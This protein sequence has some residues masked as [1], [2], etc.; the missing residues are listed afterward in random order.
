MSLCASFAPSRQKTSTAS[1]LLRVGCGLLVALMTLLISP[2][3]AEERLRVGMPEPG[4]I[5]FLWQDEDGR[6][7]GIYADTL[8]RVAEEMGVGLEFVPLS[9][10]RLR[11][12]FIAGEIDIEAGVSRSLEVP[13]ALE[14]VSL[15]SL[16]F[17]L[18]NEVFIYKPGLSFP[19]FI[20]KDLAGR[21]VATVRGTSVPDNLIR[22]DFANQ[23]QIAQRVH[24]GWNDVGLMKEAPA[25]HFR[26]AGKLNYE[27]SLPYTSNPIVFR[28]HASRFVYL[29]T[30]NDAISK[31]EASGELES[32]VCQYLCGVQTGNQPSS[33]H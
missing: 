10:A 22:E 19:V 24:R 21:R 18:A 4:Q 9:Q 33:Q 29:S 5:P 17:G 31:L 25:L 16:P 23:W 20:L 30:M 7:K 6:Y 3:H 13:K 28:L 14:Q 15:Y 26:R 32:I 2:L 12:H 27:I 11:R 1:R 8:R